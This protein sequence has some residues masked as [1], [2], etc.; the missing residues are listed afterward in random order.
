MQIIEEY[1]KSCNKGVMD[2]SYNLCTVYFDN[3]DFTW[4]MKISYTENN[5]VKM[6]FTT[7]TDW[8]KYY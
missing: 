7:C 8:Q 6:N 3:I 4:R 2:K 5:V 1:G